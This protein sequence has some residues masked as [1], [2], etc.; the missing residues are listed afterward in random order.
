MLSSDTFPM[1]IDYFKTQCNQFQSKLRDKQD[2]HIKLQEEFN[3]LNLMSQRF[4]ESKIKM[5]NE[6]TDQKSKIKLLEGQIEIKK[7][8]LSSLIQDTNDE[9]FHKDMEHKQEIQKMFANIKDA[10]IK[11]N[12]FIKRINGNRI[13]MKELDCLDGKSIELLLKS[14]GDK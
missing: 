11:T 8:Y 3:K 12:E 5:L 14:M 13:G 10:T 2:E 4:V 9:A 1:K 6:I 7:K